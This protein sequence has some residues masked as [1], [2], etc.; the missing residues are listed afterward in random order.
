MRSNE[1]ARRGETLRMDRTF[2]RQGPVSSGSHNTGGGV[3]TLIHS[4]MAYSPVSV[5]S[6]SSQDPYSDYICVKVLF[7]N[8]FPLQF[9]NLYSPPI[10]STPSD[11]CTRTFLLTSFQTPLTLLSLEISMLTTQHGTVSSPLTRPEM[12]CFAGSLPPV[13]KS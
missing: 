1:T 12:T 5:S 7:S 8:H 11:S 10:R 6:L 9:L 2:G 3:L 4:D 13:W